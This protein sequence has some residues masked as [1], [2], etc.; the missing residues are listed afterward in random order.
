MRLVSPCVSPLRVG[1]QCGDSDF[2]LAAGVLVLRSWPEGLRRSA[3]LS[4][5]H[6]TATGPTG[7][8]IPV[9]A[10]VDR[11]SASVYACLCAPT[12]RSRTCS[13]GAA[14]CS[15]T[16]RVG[17][18]G[19]TQSSAQRGRDRSRRPRGARVESEVHYDRASLG[20]SCRA[21]VRGGSS[22]K[23][24]NSGHRECLKSRA[25]DTVDV[26]AGYRARRAADA[27]L[28]GVDTIAS[29]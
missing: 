8:A 22:W 15:C 4:V 10:A 19:D 7:L 20:K 23:W 29:E 13:V 18:R 26:D 21:A 25:K 28:A 17:D 3:T 5:C 24:S 16:N 6:R 1:I 12:S 14:T 9:S 11:C 2:A 27:Y